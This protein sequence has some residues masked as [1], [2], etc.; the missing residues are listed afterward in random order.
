MVQTTLLGEGAFDSTLRNAVNSNF[1]E[2]YT[3]TKAPL[4]VTASASVTTAA[5]GGRTTN[6]NAAAGLTLT[7]PASSGSG[8]TYTFF[9]GTTVTSSNVIIQVANATDVIQGISIQAGATGAATIFSTVAASDTIT[10]NGST[11]GGIRGDKITI[12]DTASGTY[13]VVCFTSITS[14]AATPFSAA[15]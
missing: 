9:I 7:L 3:G 1:T 4:N 6:I 12:Q 8:A 5:N 11:K 2:L 13:S 10:L 15:V 14:T